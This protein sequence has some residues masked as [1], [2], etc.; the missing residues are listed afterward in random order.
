MRS[1]PS[2]SEAPRVPADVKQS[3]LRRAYVRWFRPLCS[4]P[5]D[6]QRLKLFYFVWGYYPLL[7]MGLRPFA[8]LWLVYRFLRIDWNVSHAHRPYEI[9][10]V[11]L[12]LAGRP[13]D[14]KGEALV[15]CG[16]W[17]GGSSAKFSLACS[18][19]GFDLHIYDSFQ[20]VEPLSDDEKR[21]SY[22]FSGEYSA[23]ESVLKAHLIRYGEP[24]VCSIHPGWFSESLAARPVSY[25]VRA[26]YIDC[27]VAKG[28]QEALK[29]LVPCLVADGFIFSQ[30][31]HIPPVRRLL[32]DMT[33]WRPFGRGEPVESVL[34]EQLA[35]FRFPRVGPSAGGGAGWWG[36]SRR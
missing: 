26:V 14:Q 20:G 33:T 22:D 28:T 31:Y 30:D 23:S 36:S 19:M 5:I 35:M 7:G 24:R 8:T 12:A 25:P 21:G 15:E 3:R 13:P 2:E 10:R 11:C 6:Q 17:Q 29:G 18:L 16:C 9:A 32:N 4:R 34:S 1:Y 27:D